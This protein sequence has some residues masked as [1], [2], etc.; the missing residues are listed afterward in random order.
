MTVTCVPSFGATCPANLG[1]AMTVPALDP[2]RWLTLTYAVAVPLGTRGN[3]TNDVTV[4]A[5]SESNL[6][7][8]SASSTTVAVDQR[9]GVYKAYAADGR[10]RRV[11]PQSAALRRG[12]S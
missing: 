3:V 6:A 9:N 10:L 2:G 5:T 7:N 4:T 1:A 11:S 12:C 8:N